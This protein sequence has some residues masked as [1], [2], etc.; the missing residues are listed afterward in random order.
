MEQETLHD[1]LM[2]Y[3]DQGMKHLEEF[4]LDKD[5]E[6]AR[7]MFPA[8]GET[9]KEIATDRLNVDG[10]QLAD[11]LRRIGKPVWCHWAQGGDEFD[12]IV[13]DV[14][15]D[16]AAGYAMGLGFTFGQDY[17]TAVPAYQYNP[18][19]S[20]FADYDGEIEEPI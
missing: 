16:G 9:M 6:E 1:V 11:A 2:R 19:G 13:F 15:E 20:Q 10:R 4:A 18:D 5:K 12:T 3:F 14:A 8:A 17:P 7:A